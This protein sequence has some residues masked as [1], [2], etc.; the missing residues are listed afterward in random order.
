VATAST[1]TIV[2]TPFSTGSLS[3]P[4]FVTCSAADGGGF[5]VPDHMQ[6]ELGGPFTAPSAPPGDMR[7]ASRR[8]AALAG[9]STSPGESDPF[10]GFPADPARWSGATSSASPI[11][12]GTCRFL[13]FGSTVLREQAVHAASDA[14][15]VTELGV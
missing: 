14:A 9:L 3:N 2:T 12:A 15:V 10:E 4:P 5:A 1:D 13:G 7:S 8:E 6:A 11:G